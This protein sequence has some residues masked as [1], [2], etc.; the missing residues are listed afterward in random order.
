MLNTQEVSR[1]ENHHSGKAAWKNSLAAPHQKGLDSE[2]SGG[3]LGILKHWKGNNWIS[4]GVLR[5]YDGYI[6]DTGTTYCLWL[7]QKIS[8]GWPFP[9]NTFTEDS[10]LSCLELW[11]ALISPTTGRKLIS[12]EQNYM[13]L[14]SKPVGTKESEILRGWGLRMRKSRD[15]H[16]GLEARP[17]LAS[18][19]YF[20]DQTKP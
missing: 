11:V 17:G 18:E 16:L 12:K 7:G 2:T 14:E 20:R 13:L 8:S 19:N 6:A 15:S 4:L 5:A 1:E 3:S 9:I 10:L